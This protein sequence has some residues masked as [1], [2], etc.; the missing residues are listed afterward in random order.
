MSEA[1]FRHKIGDALYDLYTDPDGQLPDRVRLY[2]V[3]K[4]TR[5]FVDVRGDQ[6]G[7]MCWRD[8]IFRF[9]REDLETKGRA[10]NQA[11]RMALYV[12]PM[13][14]WP[15]LVVDVRA[16]GQLAIAGA[17]GTKEN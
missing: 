7:P 11:H 5:C 10:W 2:P 15:L 1:D 12:R 14:D 13:P 3:V 9:S 16:S 6:A 8:M 17:P 4:V